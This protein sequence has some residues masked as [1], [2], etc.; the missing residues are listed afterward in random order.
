MSIEHVNDGSLSVLEKVDQLFK[1]DKGKVGIPVT[2]PFFQ[3]TLN[4]RPAVLFSQVWSEAIPSA[5]PSD[6]TV[7]TDSSLDETGS[8]VMAGSLVG[9]LSTLNTTIKRYIK[10]PMIHVPGA[11]D[12]GYFREG[13]FEDAIPFN[14]DKFGTYEIKLYKS[15]GVQI[16]FGE[17]GGDWIINHEYGAITFYNYADIT[18]VDQNNPP[19]ISFYRYVG[20]K[21]VTGSGG[22]FSTVFNNGDGTCGDGAV[23]ISIDTLRGNL[24][25]LLGEGDCSYALQFGD[26]ACGSWRLIVKGNGDGTTSLHFQYRANIANTWET[27]MHIDPGECDSAC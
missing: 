4:V 25:T 14:H 6:L 9:K 23:A 15:T 5:A 1:R 19:L 24:G 11:N 17:T 12:L 7:L 20:T 2:R 16:P 26:G 21:G 3:E 13:I 22:G 8:T 27:K 10:V 18:G